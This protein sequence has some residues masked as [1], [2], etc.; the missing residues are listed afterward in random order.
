MKPR[1]ILSIL[2]IEMLGKWS[3]NWN[4]DKI[5]MTGDE[6]MYVSFLPKLEKINCCAPNLWFLGLT[7]AGRFMTHSAVLQN[8]KEPWAF[9][10]SPK[11]Q[12]FMK[13]EDL[14]WRREPGLSASLKFPH[15]FFWWENTPQAN[16]KPVD[17]MLK[18]MLCVCV[19][20]FEMTTVHFS[21]WTAQKK[22]S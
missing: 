22:E 1:P 18:A 12:D 8:G 11:C 3:L 16:V 15:F 20:D 6:A 5:R 9:Y 19:W 10:F 13:A 17:S 14:V 2:A 21:E 4:I 7:W